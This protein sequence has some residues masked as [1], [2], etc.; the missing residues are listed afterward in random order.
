MTGTGRQPRA[1]P[2]SRKPASG[3]R[4]DLAEKLRALQAPLGRSLARA[5]VLA[6]MIRAVNASL[7]PERVAE[8]VV[9]RVSGWIPAS[10][11]LVVAVGLDGTGLDGIVVI[12]EAT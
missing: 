12:G 5:D 1:R 11:W 10:G 7:D 6:D 3:A 2:S 9:A 4:Q 8:A